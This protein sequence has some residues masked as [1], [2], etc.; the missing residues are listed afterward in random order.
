MPQP[1]L[2]PSLFRSI[3]TLDRRQDGPVPRA[4]RAEA[5]YATSLRKIARAVG[6]IIRGFDLLDDP[7]ALPGMTDALRRYSQAITPWAGSVARRMIAEVGSRERRYWFENSLEISRG[8]RDEIQ[9]APTGAVMREALA[10]QVSLITS[11]PTEA[12]ERV[13]RLT[14]EALSTGRRAED[15][16][17]EIARSGEVTESRARLIARTEVSR[18]ATELT[19]ARML[20]IGSTE[21][22][23][24]TAGDTDVRPSHKRLNGKVFSWNDPPEADPGYRCHPGTIFNC[25]CVA[26]PLL[27]E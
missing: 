4:R 7:A 1:S 21:Y 19:K 9:N 26:R 17:K 23:W 20:H 24:V 12:G 25:R 18:T 22:V 6:D 2:D 13:H 5:Q 14:T 10:N 27:P 16:A 15:I 8:L 11:L 3:R